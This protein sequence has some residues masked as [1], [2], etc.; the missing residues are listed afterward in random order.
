MKRVQPNE[1]IPTVYHD[2][3]AEFYNVQD[4]MYL[5]KENLTCLAIFWEDRK[6]KFT[7][8]WADETNLDKRA[9]YKTEEEQCGA[10]CRYLKNIIPKCESKP[11]F[12]AKPTI[13][14]GTRVAFFATEP[15][16]YIVGTVA[17]IKR[18]EASKK[19]SLI[20]RKDNKEPATSYEY[21]QYRPDG[22]SMFLADDLDY[23]R[24]H[25]AYF[26]YVVNYLAKPSNPAENDYID[27]LVAALH[28]PTT[29]DSSDIT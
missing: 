2:G 13:S 4:L 22:F 12:F 19:G 8:K 18:D 10:R 28:Q 9:M 27:R 26:R 6:A 3:L 21:W 16:C 1:C 15:D 7:K 23:Y 17:E 24:E 29:P 20:I 11:I 25:P 14:I 5:G